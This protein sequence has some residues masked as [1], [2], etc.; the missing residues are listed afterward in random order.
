MKNS[1]QKKYEEK[2]ETRENSRKFK[3]THE[4]AVIKTLLIKLGLFL[5]FLFM[6]YVNDDSEIN[7]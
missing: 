5:M 7:I 6:T 3:T 4:H 2:S 1:L